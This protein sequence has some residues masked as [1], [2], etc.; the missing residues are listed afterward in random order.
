MQEHKNHLYT[1]CAE[2]DAA[3]ITVR[4]IRVFLPEGFA[5]LPPATPVTHVRQLRT[6]RIAGFYGFRLPPT[7]NNLPRSKSFFP[8]AA[9]VQLTESAAA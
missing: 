6:D 7:G 3:P 8:A 2:P 1:N 5:V 9:K 4:K